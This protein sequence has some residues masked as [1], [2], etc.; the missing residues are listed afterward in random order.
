MLD[1]CNVQ[2]DNPVS[3]LNQDTSRHFLQK[4][5]PGDKYKL[6]M[7]ATHLEQI[8]TDYELAEQD[9]MIMRD[10]IT[11]HEAVGARWLCEGVWHG[12]DD[13]CS[14]C[15]GVWPRPHYNRFLNIAPFILTSPKETTPLWPTVNRF[16][17]TCTHMCMHVRTHTH[18]AAARLPGQSQEVGGESGYL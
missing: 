17:C 7:K 5:K 16:H 2:V 6:F 15:E 3:L 1:H 9:Q 18:V 12:A 8:A 4:N 10:G 11:R 13:G 14:L